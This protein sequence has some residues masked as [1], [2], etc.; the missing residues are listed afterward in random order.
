MAFQ[1]SP[2]V[3]VKEQDFTS[4]VPNVA[5]SSGAFA[6]NFQWGPIEDPVQIVSENN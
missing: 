1:L 4:I 5:T 6:G 2:G 3:V